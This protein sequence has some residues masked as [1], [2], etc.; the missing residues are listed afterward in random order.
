MNAGM[1]VFVLEQSNHIGG[2]WWFDERAKTC[3]L[4][5][6]TA[7]TRASEL[8]FPG[9]PFED[10]RGGYPTASEY[11]LYLQSFADRFDLVDLI[12]FNAQVEKVTP[13]DSNPSRWNVQITDTSINVPMAFEVDF[14]VLANGH[15]QKPRLYTDEEVPGVES[16][17]SQIHS[18]QFRSTAAVSQKNVLVVGLG[19][20]GVEILRQISGVAQ[21]VVACSMRMTGGN[22]SARGHISPRKKTP[23]S[24]ADD[25]KRFNSSGDLSAVASV[26]P[27][28][29]SIKNGEVTFEDKTTFRPDLIIWCTGFVYDFPFI[30][31]NIIS[32]KGGRVELYLHMFP[33]SALCFEDNLA[34]IGLPSVS[35]TQS[36]VALACEQ[37]KFFAAV[38]T[39]KCELPGKKEREAWLQERRKTWVDHMYRPLQ[40]DFKVYVTELSGI[41]G[42]NSVVVQDRSFQNTARNSDEGDSEGESEEGEGE[43]LSTEE[44]ATPKKPVAARAAVAPAAA[45]SPAPSIVAPP[46]AT[47]I[48]APTS[49]MSQPRNS[50]EAPSPTQSAPGSRK[51]TL[52]KAEGMVM[53]KSGAAAPQTMASPA[54]SRMANQNVPPAS[55]SMSRIQPHTEL[56][57]SKT[58]VFA[59][60]K[61]TPVK[62]GTSGLLD[63]FRA[64]KKSQ[65]YPEDQFRKQVKILTN[66]VHPLMVCVPVSAACGEIGKRDLMEDTHVLLDK[67]PGVPETIPS[68]IWC[69]YD[70]HGGQEVSRMAEQL[71]H[72][73]IQKMLI[74]SLIIE[75]KSVG[76]I[77][78]DRL[79]RKCFKETDRT[80]CEKLGELKTVGSTV[81][82]CV[83]LGRK[84]FV[85]N[86]GDSEV[87]V[88]VCKVGDASASAIEMS[89][90]HK[91]RNDRE[92]T[93]I[94]TLGGMVFGGRVYGSL[95]VARGFGDSQFK[96]PTNPQFI[97]APDPDVKCLE[98]GPQHRYI[99]L[100]CDGLWDKVTHEEAAEYVHELRENGY[101]LQEC[102]E[103]LVKE[104]DDRISRDNI[105][106]VVVDLQWS[107]D[108][109]LE[110]PKTCTECTAVTF[111]LTY[112]TKC[113]LPWGPVEVDTSV[114]QAPSVKGKRERSYKPKKKKEESSDEE[115][116]IGDPTNVVHTGH[117]NTLEDMKT[118]LKNK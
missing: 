23:R 67:I 10:C 47:P 95:S 106:V 85:A 114:R 6:L 35:G 64:E 103:W 13:S 3:V 2:V 97:I 53:Q 83:L 20:S 93:R 90:K 43:T 37:S 113:G 42:L 11:C 41:L 69:V 88:S 14:V 109:K 39:G 99:I 52:A 1:D 9:F 65:P 81:A 51:A 60:F 33:T 79:L 8:S 76:E 82:V 73:K 15:Y 38:A 12:R 16:F 30:S 32:V 84:L 34:V 102:A 118:M 70:G 112:C 26:R 7:N 49:V 68:G 110:N 105:T 24:I 104:A 62:E 21:E 48:P 29:K 56:N 5:N 31:Q 46:A 74:N 117:A 45:T 18:S 78:M 72:V 100:A 63:R 71:L 36:V 66:S 75:G 87:V 57:S 55:P 17:S 22:K 80:I 101:S 92:K 108:A 89:H 40:I 96:P 94:E 4:P 27:R 61:R 98:I 44:E 107:V 19:A 54:M 25:A 115:I 111:G 77:N 116:Q 91:P 58:G 59:S 28:I 86:A 50:D